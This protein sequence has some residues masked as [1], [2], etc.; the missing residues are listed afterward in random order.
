MRNI[1]QMLIITFSISFSFQVF[2]AEEYRH[3]QIRNGETVQAWNENLG[4]WVTPEEFWAHY[5]ES[6][7]GI[8]WGQREDYPPYSQ[9]KELDTLMIQL[10]SGLCLMEFFH[11]RWRRANDVRRWDPAFNEYG[12]CRDVFN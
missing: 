9:V 1:I 5:A 8:T 10:E 7:G 3:G 4:H 11:S 12:A 6:R 2:A